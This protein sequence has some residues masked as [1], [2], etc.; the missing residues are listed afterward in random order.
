MARKIVSSY[1]VFEDVDGMRD[2]VFYYQGGGADSVSG[3][4]ATEADYILDLLR[5]EK[6]I[7]YDHVLK[8]LSTWSPE[9]VGEAEISPNLDAWL[10]AYPSIAASIV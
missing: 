10:N 3:V 7:S 1:A 6:P 8:R 4:S 5:K 2:I 9:E